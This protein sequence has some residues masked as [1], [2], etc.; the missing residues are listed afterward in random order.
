[1]VSNMSEGIEKLIGHSIAR[2]RKDRELT[3]AQLAEMIDTTVETISRLERG[4]SIPSLKT[5]VKI[6]RALHIPIKE[7][8]DFEY[9][10]AKRASINESEK[11]LAYLQTKK[12]EEIRMC[13]RILKNIFE[14]IKKTYQTKR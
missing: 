9:A 4:V 6:S 10:T 13:Y 1:M 5:L 11:L 12:P 3:Q 7:L 8:M 2:I 14:Q